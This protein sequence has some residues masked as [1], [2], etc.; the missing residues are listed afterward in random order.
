MSNSKVLQFFLY[1]GTPARYFTAVQLKE[2]QIKS[3][4]NFVI[5]RA[6]TYLINPVQLLR[7][8][9]SP[10]DVQ[11]TIKLL[12]NGLKIFLRSFYRLTTKK[13]LYNYLGR[14]LKQLADIKQ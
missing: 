2:M 5:Y 3:Y 6:F 1:I 14:D 9:H 4:R 10:E 12:Y 11:Y 7:K 13:L 8:M